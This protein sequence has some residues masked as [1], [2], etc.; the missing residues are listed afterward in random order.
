MSSIRDRIVT[1]AREFET[2]DVSTAKERYLEL[3]AGP[4]DTEP[5]QRAYLAAPK[6]SGCALVVRGLW[7]RLGLSD[8]LLTERY[9]SGM[10]VGDVVAIARKHGAWVT[11]L[12]RLPQPGDVILVGD[13]GKSGVE[14]VATIV[15]VRADGTLESV[16]GGQRD[17]AG[18]Q[19][20]RHKV[21]TWERRADGSVWDRSRLASD[22]GSGAPRRVIGFVNV[23][24][25]PFP[26]AI[27]PP[28]VDGAGGHS[29]PPP[30]TERAPAVEGNPWFV[31]IGEASG[32]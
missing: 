19:A 17:K 10:A 30:D 28:E 2:V 25:L 31:G 15:A 4:G 16:D 6:T 1:I 5:G 8:R 22:P 13:N 23:E 12:S 14:H 3:V 9:R 7:R 26:A 18:Q 32:D 27:E 29:L 11:D 21:R 20:I 24:A